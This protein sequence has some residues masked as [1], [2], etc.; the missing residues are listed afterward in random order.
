MQ[1]AHHCPKIS[2]LSACHP[3]LRRHQNSALELMAHDREQQLSQ[4]PNWASYLLISPTTPLWLEAS[5]APAFRSLPQ[6]A[7]E[8]RS[9]LIWMKREESKTTGIFYLPAVSS[10]HIPFQCRKVHLIHFNLFSFVFSAE[11]FSELFPPDLTWRFEEHMMEPD[12]S[13][14]CSARRLTMRFQEITLS[15]HIKTAENIILF[16][17]FFPFFF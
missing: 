15:S 2:S 14:P 12:Q 4:S 5:Q 3:V 1:A 10:E 16:S 11:I 6:G 9:W 8:S 7:L 13:K 17:F